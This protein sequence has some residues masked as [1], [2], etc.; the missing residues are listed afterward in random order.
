[1]ELEELT[2]LIIVRLD[3]IERLE[4]ILSVT[5]FLSSNF[6]S[7]IAVAEYSAYNNGLLTKLLAKKI[8]YSFHEDPDPI[9]YRT[10]FLN[11]MTQSVE[12]PFVTV[13][14][15]D[16]IVPPNQIIK[17]MEL[18]QKKEAD[19]VYP[20]E[21]EFLDTTPILRKLFIKEGRIAIL[22][23]NA[24]KM[25]KMYLP[26]PAGGAFFASLSAYKNSGLEN[27]EFYGWGMEDAERLYRWKN[28]GYRIK[29]VPGPLFHLSHGRGINSWFHNADQKFFKRKEVMN[30][31]RS[32]SERINVENFNN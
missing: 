32:S 30:L 29:R 26:N 27:E 31:R 1:M 14:D 19:F 16:I 13:W 4:N 15:S 17:A 12:T 11:Q 7:N 8:R 21:K 3:S 20:Y 18:L 5:K 24:K 22:E 28:L 6:K 10:K 9:L 2:F 25:I 23:R